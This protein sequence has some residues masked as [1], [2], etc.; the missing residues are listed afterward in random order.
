MVEIFLPLMAP[1]KDKLQ[2]FSGWTGRR[3]ASTLFDYAGGDTKSEEG[4]KILSFAGKVF[5]LAKQDLAG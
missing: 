3:I 1:F 5:E 2:R 4:K